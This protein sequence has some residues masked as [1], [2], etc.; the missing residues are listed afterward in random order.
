MVGKE[1]IVDGKPS[2]N[3]QLAENTFSYKYDNSCSKVKYTNT[4]V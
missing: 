3:N 1:G 4:A 2:Q